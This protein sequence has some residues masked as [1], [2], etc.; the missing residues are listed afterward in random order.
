MRLTSYLF[1]F[2]TLALGAELK[3]PFEKYTLK[4]G[5]RVI[6]SRDSGAPVVAVYLI[7]DVGARAEEKGRSGFAHLFEHMMFQGSK[8]APKGMHFKTVEANG[9]DLNGSTHPDF[10]DYFET[11]PSNKL[12]VALWLESDRMREL[13]IT[14]ENLANQKEAVKEERRM[15]VDNQPYA[16][17]IVDLFPE[18]VFRN[19][20]NS[21]S[22]IGSFEDLNAAGVD[23]VSRFF[24]TYYAPNNAV[25]VVA[26][27]LNPAEAR[28]WID[29]YFSDIP[30]QPRPK[31][32]DLAEPT[33]TESRWKKHS[34]KLAQVP[35]LAVAWPGPKRRSPDYNALVMLDAVLTA[36]PSSRF[37]L[38]LVKGKESLVSYE[39]NLSWP[40]GSANDYRDPGVYGIWVMHKPQF[41]AR[42]VVDQVSGEIQRI[43]KEGVPEKELARVRAYVESARIREVQSMQRRA[44]LLGQYE[45]FD[46]DAGLVN[47]EL[48]MLAKVTDKQIQDVAGRYFPEARRSVLEVAPEPKKEAK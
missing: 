10:T 3:I 48:G 35:A 31:R 38:N 9:G 33:Q 2:S 30:S 25:L 37:A 45:V 23:D 16:L 6:L 29:V 28:K 8:N 20:S 41:T 5:L 32:P 21:H 26:G 40:F 18:L 12:P 1:A 43:A 11:L 47:T 19:W 36:G 15:R 46:G 34:D 13:N 42:Q 39:A 24:K 44:A 7:Y 27:D 22:I 17:G 14:A 4:N